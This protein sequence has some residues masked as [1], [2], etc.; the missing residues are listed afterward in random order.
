MARTLPSQTVEIRIS[1]EEKSAANALRYLAEAK[2]YE[3]G[4]TF[5]LWE[6]EPWIPGE[7]PLLLKKRWSD[8]GERDRLVQ[9]IASWANEI[10]P[11]ESVCVNAF[12]SEPPEIRARIKEQAAHC[13]QAKTKNSEIHIRSAFKPGYH[14]VE[15]ELIPAS[16]RFPPRSAASYSTAKGSGKRTVWSF[17]SAGFR[18]FSR[19]TGFSSGN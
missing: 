3:E 15:E 8:R 1:G 2:P 5:G 10:G 4:G 19:P 9:E 11:C 13:L 6:K 7:E 18:S 14:W 16:G 17:P 12:V